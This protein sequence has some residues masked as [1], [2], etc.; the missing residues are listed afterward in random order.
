MI[1]IIFDVNIL[2][3]TEALLPRPASCLRIALLISDFL[4]CFNIRRR[5]GFNDLQGLK[6]LFK[7]LPWERKKKNVAP[8]LFDAEKSRRNEA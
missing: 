1:L 3:S 2:T 5:A 4:P 8:C 6:D 7:M